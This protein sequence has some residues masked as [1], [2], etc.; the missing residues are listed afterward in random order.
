[1]ATTI[2]A[3]RKDLIAKL[4]S[5]KDDNV[6]IADVVINR[7]KLLEAL[8]LQTQ[9]DTITLTYGKVSWGNEIDNEPC[10]QFSCNHTVM[11]FLNRPK[12][13]RHGEPKVKHLN[14]IDYRAETKTE[15][16]GTPIDPQELIKALSFVLPCV[17]TEQTRPVLNCILF[18]NA[19]NTI[20]LVAADGFRLGIDKVSADGIPA[21]KVLIQLADIP[22][23]LT[24]L[25]AVKPT[26]KGKLKEYP[27][28]YLSY[29]EQSIRLATESGYLDLDKQQ[30]TFPDYT[31][32]IPKDGTH[33]QLIASDM[34]ESVK[35]LN[36]IAKDGSG[37]IR[38]QFSKYPD[39]LTLSAKAGYEE[40]ETQAECQAVV[41]KP[42]KIAINSKYLIDLL[43]LCGDNAIDLFVTQPSS[44]MVCHNGLDQLQVIMPMFVQWGDK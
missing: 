38:L 17:A 21:D 9:E 18:E 13:N 42:C 43:K 11:R 29:N 40:N 32:L 41:D 12:L 36:A 10:L 2:K 20:K 33:I 6:S 19:D 23:L 1:M 22:R 35:A 8:R 7:S 44:P 4:A 16:T 25:R 15:L 14:F 34:L 39:K 5:V 31:Q 30:G 24:L 3:N 27:Q 37:I 26:G 28:V